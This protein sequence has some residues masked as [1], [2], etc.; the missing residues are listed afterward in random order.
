MHRDPHQ[1]AQIAAAMWLAGVAGVLF[2]GP[3][4]GIPGPR[5]P[6]EALVAGVGLAVLVGAVA[7]GAWREPPD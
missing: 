5:S 7:V 6:L 4:L 1:L 3:A 2:L